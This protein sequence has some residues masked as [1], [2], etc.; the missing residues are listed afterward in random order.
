M[1]ETAHLDHD[2]DESLSDGMINF[3]SEPKAVVPRFAR[4]WTALLMVALSLTFIG[5]AAQ[6]DA[7]DE[8]AEQFVQSLIDEGLSILQNDGVSLDEKKQV[9]GNLVLNNADIPGMARF[10]L[11]KYRRNMSSEQLS[12]FVTFVRAIHEEFLRDAVRRVWRRRH[13]RRELQLTEGNRKGIVV[14]SHM[15]LAPESIL[16]SELEGVQKV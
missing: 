7:R 9:F 12:E 15:E 3:A 6:A 2:V 8:A 11:G 14:E 5:G 13:R 16:G 4:V 1:I 10:T